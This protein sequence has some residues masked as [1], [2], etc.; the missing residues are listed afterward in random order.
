MDARWAEDGLVLF[1]LHLG[2]R[3]ILLAEATFS[4]HGQWMGQM[5]CPKNADTLHLKSTLM[6]SS[7]DDARSAISARAS[8]TRR[9]ASWY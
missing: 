6:V 2:T 7:L 5:A 9:H 3:R 8:L 1:V 4:P